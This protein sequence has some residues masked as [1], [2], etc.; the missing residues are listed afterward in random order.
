MLAF[1]P[2]VTMRNVR[3]IV[4]TAVAMGAGT[5]ERSHAAHLD[6][7]LYQQAG[8]LHLGGYDFFRRQPLPGLHV[9]ESVLTV[10]PGQPGVAYTDNPGWATAPPDRL[11]L[12][13]DGAESLPAEASI[14]FDIVPSAITG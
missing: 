4:L 5:I 11:G 14:S 8:Q 9:F 10:F 3:F 13:P 12:L 6:M 7:M 2:V 1:Y